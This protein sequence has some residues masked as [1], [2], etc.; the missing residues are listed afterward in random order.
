MA[1]PRLPPNKIVVA[2]AKLALPRPVCAENSAFS[3]RRAELAQ[4]LRES[5]AR[6]FDDWSPARKRPAHDC[7]AGNNSPPVSRP[8]A[9]A[10]AGHLMRRGSA[11][12]G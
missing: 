5:V 6:D 10:S 4:A 2:M 3:G 9:A 1:V 7:E 12:L 8:L 11:S